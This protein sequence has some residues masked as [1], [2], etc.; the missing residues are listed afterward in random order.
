MRSI[1]QLSGGDSTMRQNLLFKDF[2]LGPEN[3]EML[4]IMDHE[5]QFATA[6]R[7][8]FCPKEAVLDRKKLD[9]DTLKLP[10]SKSLYINWRFWSLWA[11]HS[12]SRSCNTIGFCL[13]VWLVRCFLVAWHYKKQHWFLETWAGCPRSPSDP[14]RHCG[15]LF[16]DYLHQ[17]SY[18]PDVWALHTTPTTTGNFPFSWSV[19]K[20]LL[21]WGSDHGGS[22]TPLVFLKAEEPPTMVFNATVDLFTY[23]YLWPVPKSEVY[24]VT[25]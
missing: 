16:P 21:I 4:Q 2:F 11:Q 9:M 8:E 22:R 23:T 14:L 5:G 19:R 10:V 25:C 3:K 17:A 6:P 18:S 1:L 20:L 15:I 13:S 24:S 7:W 12:D